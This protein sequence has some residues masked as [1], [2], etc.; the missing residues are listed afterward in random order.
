MPEARDFA[1]L[2]AQW[3]RLYTPAPLI[4]YAPSTQG[5]SPCGCLQNKRENGAFPPFSH[6]TSVPI[7]ARLRAHWDASFRISPGHASLVRKSAVTSWV[8]A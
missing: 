7:C 2:V 4:P 1:A 6:K 8:P 5:L 3:L